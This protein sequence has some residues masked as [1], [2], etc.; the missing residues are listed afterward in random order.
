MRRVAKGL[1]NMRRVAKGSRRWTARWLRNMRHVAKGF[2]TCAM[3]QRSFITCAVLQRGA[4]AGPLDRANRMAT[5]P[6]DLCKR[7]AGRRVARAL[8]SGAPSPMAYDFSSKL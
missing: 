2:T 3:L 7:S 4:Y 6:A 8:I 1:R 5:D